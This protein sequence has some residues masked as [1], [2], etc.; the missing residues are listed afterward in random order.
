MKYGFAYESC[1]S[2]HSL[3]VNPRPVPEA[4]SRYYT[5]SPSSKYWASTFYKE[6]ADARREKLWK[7]K[8]RLIRDKLAHYGGNHHTIIDIGGGFGI[9][10]EEM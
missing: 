4:F 7:P 3:F 6:T 2:C 1:P 5:E 8:A 9:F 10:A